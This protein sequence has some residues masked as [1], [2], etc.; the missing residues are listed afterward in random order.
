MDVGQNTTRG[1]G[2]TSKQLVQLLVILNSKGNV[3]GHDTSL[4]V[5]TGGIAGKLKKSV[6]ALQKCE[7]DNDESSISSSEGSNHFQM[8]LD[9]LEE[10]NP[11]IVLALLIWI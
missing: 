8:D 5:V 11:K 1:N 2:N 3:T 4:L 7:E 9:L 6:S 10:Q